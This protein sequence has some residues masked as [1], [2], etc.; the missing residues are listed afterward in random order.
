MAHKVEIS[1][2]EILKKLRELKPYLQKEFGVK[3]IGI[4]GS[5]VRNEQRPDSDI[6]ILIDYDVKVM[7]SVFKLIKLKFFLEEILGKKVDLVP[8]KGIRPQLREK[9]L[10]EVIYA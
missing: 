1:K 9:I 6:D 4:F 2:E 5:V 7:R 8:K 10:N 3:E